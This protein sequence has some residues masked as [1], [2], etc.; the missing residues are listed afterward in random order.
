METVEKGTPDM[1][2]V[3]TIAE[4]CCA[5]CYPKSRVVGSVLG[6]LARIAS[7]LEAT[8]KHAATDISLV[9]ARPH[10]RAP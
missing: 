6:D 1:P 2:A 5:I 9:V 8:T 7:L 3:V 4:R 10:N